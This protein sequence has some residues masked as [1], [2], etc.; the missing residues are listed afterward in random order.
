M[1]NTASS[2]RFGRFDPVRNGETLGAYVVRFS[3]TVDAASRTERKGAS[4]QLIS[5]HRLGLDAYTLQTGD[6]RFRRVPDFPITC[7][8]FCAESAFGPIIITG[9]VAGSVLIYDAM[10]LKPIG[11]LSDGAGGVSLG[12]SPVTAIAVGRRGD[13]IVLVGN[14]SGATIVI[15]IDSGAKKQTLRT[16]KFEVQSPGGSSGG[17]GSGSVADHGAVASIAL[18]GAAANPIVAVGFSD[19]LVHLFAL[20]AGNWLRD[21]RTVAR[22]SANLLGMVSLPSTIVGAERPGSGLSGGLLLAFDKHPTKVWV[23]D[24]GGGAPTVLDF[25]R[26]LIAVKM[27]TSR[28]ARF[29][30]DEQRAILFTGCDDGAFFVRK[31]TRHQPSGAIAIALMKIGDPAAT[32]SKLARDRS[33]AVAPTVTSLNYDTNA[34]A[35]VLGD[36]GGVARTV[37]GVTGIAHVGGGGD[38]RRREAAAA[39]KAEAAAATAAASA[40]AGPGSAAVAEA[41]AGVEAGAGGSLGEA[42]PTLAGEARASGASATAPPAAPV[43]L[44]A[45]SATA[46]RDLWIDAA[47]A[48]AIVRPLVGSSSEEDASS[49]TRSGAWGSFTVRARGSAVTALSLSLQASGRCVEPLECGGE[50]EA[51]AGAWPCIPLALLRG[52]DDPDD[53]SDALARAWP[54]PA[55]SV[56][57]VLDETASS[58]TRIVTRLECAVDGPIAALRQ[59]VAVDVAGAAIT[60]RLEVEAREAVTVRAGLHCAFALAP[61]RFGSTL[62]APPLRSAVV[63]SDAVDAESDDGVSPLQ[64]GSPFATLDAVP[65]QPIAGM[66]GGDFD[67]SRAPLGT[68]L[69]VLLGAVLRGPEPDAL[70]RLTAFYAATDAGKDVPTLIAKYGTLGKGNVDVLLAD[71]LRKYG[72]AAFEASDAV[73]AA[74]AS[75]AQSH[76]ASAFHIAHAREAGGSDYAASLQ[77]RGA[78]LPELFVHLDQISE[79]PCLGLTPAVAGLREG[80]ALRAVAAGESWSLEC[81]IAVEEDLDAEGSGEDKGE[82]SQMREDEML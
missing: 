1:G 51:K 64:R 78:A 70:A 6:R 55:A 46:V 80:S 58:E 44:A 49:W 26:E 40:R 29:T 72:A 76:V 32:H 4:S 19:A 10:W 60:I 56:V 45:L 61:Q 8:A 71:V 21:L 27:P 5:V 59:T 7:C 33:D 3:A 39:A 74:E 50:G 31:L 62:T 81:R 53:D 15:D 69:N 20:K 24:L 54:V 73:A 79:R 23:H 35:L 66:S 37:P 48:E 14:E 41:G 67:L 57:W 38:E 82:M 52:A 28:I 18:C 43:A 65:M 2:H 13:G 22:D 17:G 42:P 63:L 36:S 34:D 47:D 68:K 12:K 30:F 16:P 25:S 75:A 9:D 11:V 77:W